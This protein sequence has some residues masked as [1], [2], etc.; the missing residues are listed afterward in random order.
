MNLER[1]CVEA[2]VE[3][4]HAAVAAPQWS[5]KGVVVEHE[6]IVIT[7]TRERVGR[8]TKINMMIATRRTPMRKFISLNPFRAWL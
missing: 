1:T 3:L 7:T 8:E 6:A 2:E 4:I 5:E